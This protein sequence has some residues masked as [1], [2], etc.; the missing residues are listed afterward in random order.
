ML[1]AAIDFRPITDRD[2]E[3]LY[4]VYAST[5]DEEMAM[6]PWSDEQKQEFLRMQFNAQHTFYTEQFSEAEFQ[7]IEE[8]GEGIGRLYVERRDDEIRVIDIALLP[9][10]RGKGLGAKLM[11]QVL[12]EAAAVNK[13]VRIHVERENPA[14][15]LYDRLGFRK[16][17]EQG[18]YYL[19]EWSPTVLDR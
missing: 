10:H 9:Q 4:A 8:H 12:D 6:V 19:M 18:V 5:R 7:I 17:E 15:R 13:R 2:Q 1:S 3:F 14:M 16:I 11:Q